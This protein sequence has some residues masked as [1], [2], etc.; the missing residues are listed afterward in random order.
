MENSGFQSLH[1]LH[2]LDPHH[3]W[4]ALP[5]G[6]RY[7]GD[8]GVPRGEHVWGH[9]Q[10]GVDQ[11]YQRHLLQTGY[12]DD[13]IVRFLDALHG[14]PAYDDTLVMV[15][16]DHGIAFG[17]GGYFRGGT[18]ENIEE[19]A[20][21]PLFVK[22]PGQ[23][24]GSIDNRPAS[25]HDVLPTIVDVL[26][27]DSAWSMIGTSLL[28]KDP[29]T[30]RERIFDGVDTVQLPPQHPPVDGTTSRKLE[31]FG[32]GQGWDRVYNFGPHRDLV[33]M[34][35]AELAEDSEAADVGL[36]DAAL[37][38][39]VDASTGVV[40]ALVRASVRSDSVGADTWLAVALNGTIATTAR[41]HDWTPQ[42]AQFSAILPPTSFATGDNEIDLYRIESTHRGP[43]LHH[44][45][46]R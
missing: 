37:Y 17:A 44:L 29:D 22:A 21:I 3:P 42:G 10:Y 14:S 15:M 34:G 23:V 16:A 19:I 7:P 9:D 24:D 36:V 2:L 18:K 1:F 41:V 30:D 5:G 12:V 46:D 25:L 33:G 6:L 35:V 13:L 28:E 8:S 43:A 40:P 38:D 20:Y 45:E 39:H 32:S 31:L 4:N 27:I 26:E 11:A